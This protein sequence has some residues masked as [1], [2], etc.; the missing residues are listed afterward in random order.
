[1]FH[2]SVL[3]VQASPTWFWF[4]VFEFTPVNWSR[5]GGATFQRMSSFAHPKT[6]R[7]LLGKGAKPFAQPNRNQT[8]LPAIAPA[9]SEPSTQPSP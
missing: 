6:M 8:R 1:M 9:H 5:L 7:N 3:S 2:L 4:A